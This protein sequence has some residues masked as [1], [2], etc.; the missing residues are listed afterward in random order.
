MGETRERP[1]DPFCIICQEMELKDALLIIVTGD[2]RIC[3]HC[4][5]ELAAIVDDYERGGERRPQ[6]KRAQWEM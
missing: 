2:I 5:K 3:S 1:I 4:V 6:G